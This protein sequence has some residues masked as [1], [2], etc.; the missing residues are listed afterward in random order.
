MAGHARRDPRRPHAVAHRG[1][2]RRAGF[3]AD[4][5]LPR[6]WYEA[7]VDLRLR[8]PQAALEEAEAR[9]RRQALAPDGR[10][11]I[12]AADHPARMV[13]RAGSDPVGMG[14]RWALLSRVLRVLTTPDVDGVMATPDV[15]EELLMLSA[16]ARRRCGRGW[17]DDK[18]ILGCMNRGGLSGTVFEIDDRMTAFTAE[19]MARLRCD[20]AKLMVRVDPQ[21]AATAATLQACARAIDACHAIGLDVFLEAFLVDRSPAGPRPRTDAES[22]IRAAGVAAG[23]GTSTVRTW[24]KL[25]YGPGYDRVAAATT[26]PILMLGGEVRDDPAVVLDEFASGMAAGPNVRGALVGRNISFAPDEDPRAIAAA[27]AAVVHRGESAAAAR[28]LIAAERGRETD[29]VTRLGEVAA[30]GAG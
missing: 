11:L 10:L 1:A 12:L 4:A 24:L 30:G 23:L 16:L 3:D 14:N 26:L 19:G 27:V 17:L 25:P 21:D 15:V 8:R 5:F 22:L 20:G 28:A 6:A 13:T 29:T 18:V 7:V 9:M 2:A